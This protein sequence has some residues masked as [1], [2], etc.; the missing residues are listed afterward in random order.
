M[1]ILTILLA[2]LLAGSGNFTG[3][4]PGNASLV[5]FVYGGGPTTGLQPTPSG[6]TPTGDFVYGGGPVGSP[7]P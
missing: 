7:A 4:A 1:S 3:A 6:S 5:D 2:A